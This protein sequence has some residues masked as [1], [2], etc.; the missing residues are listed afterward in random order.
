M[1]KILLI[2]LPLL[3]FAQLSAQ[4]GPK[5]LIDSSL[6][7]YD[8]VTV[9][10][11][12][13]SLKDIAFCERY[14]GNKVSYSLNLGA[15]LMAPPI[16]ID[17][18]YQ[19]WE[20]D[21]ADMNGD[22]KPDLVAIQGNHQ[23]GRIH[24]FEN[25]YPSF[26]I[27]VLDSAIKYLIDFRI[28]DFDQ[29]G[30][31]DIVVAGGDSLHV[32][33]NN[34]NLNFTKTVVQMQAFENYALDVADFNNDGY[35]D[36]VVGANGI[37]IYKNTAGVLAIDTAA[38]A[39]IF[40][41]TVSV[42]NLTTGDMNNDGFMD[43][44]YAAPP[45]VHVDTNQ[46]G[47]FGHLAAIDSGNVKQNM[48]V[49]DFNGDG[50]LDFLAHRSITNEIFWKAQISPGIY[51]A[52]MAIHQADFRG[53]RVFSDD[54]NNDGK[55]DIIWCNEL[56]YHLNTTVVGIP[57]PTQLLALTCYPN[58]TSGAFRLD[59]PAAG[60]LK[61]YAMNGQEVYRLE[62]E[63]AASKELRIDLPAGVYNLYFVDQTGKIYQQ[64]LLMH[65]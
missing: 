13:D 36:L 48:V 16:E 21:A 8:V 61:I 31:M 22:G 45:Y 38:S 51:G 64:K 4:F 32:F 24:I 3:L 17:S 6:Y 26:A 58:P 42:F 57:N 35:P 18:V 65:D 19:P 43:V 39:S 30:T 49:Q 62:V 47:I 14:L 52:Q 9:D 23:Y 29:N 41:G 59:F 7:A 33:Y 37:Y 10:L 60:R 27:T 55:Y 2:L 34:G 53:A 40:P 63:G 1:K 28:A 50:K 12:G 5:I 15:G 20:I 11:N 54:L 44:I 46:N 56:A 25:N